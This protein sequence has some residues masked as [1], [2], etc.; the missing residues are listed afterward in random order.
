MEK[1]LTGVE[2]STIRFFGD[3]T[4]KGGNDYEIFDDSRTVGH[5][6]ENPEDTLRQMNE[7]FNL[8]GWAEGRWTTLKAIALGDR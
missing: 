2:D 3:K 7:L 4:Y 5:S 8:W 6:V 1:S